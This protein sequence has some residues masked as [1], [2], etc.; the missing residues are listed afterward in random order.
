MNARYT[1]HPL[2]PSLWAATAIPAPSAPPLAQDLEADVVVVGGGFAGLST[3][4]HLAEKGAT[5]CVLEAEQP[6]WGASG[7]NG[8]QVIPGL[9]YDPR[10][11]EERFGQKAESMIHMA[12]TAA[13]TVFD[14]IQKYGIDC[15]PVRNGWIQTAH[16]PAVLDVVEK[17]A[18]DWE[19]R[20]VKVEILD[21][22]AVRKR[23][24]SKQFIGGWVDYRAG[25]V[26]PLSYARGLCHAAQGLG[27]R[28]H[29]QSRVTRL[30]RTG[31]SW[32]AW[33][34]QHRVAAKDVVICT[35]GYT[36][37]LWPR[38]QKTVLPANSFLVATRPLT[39]S[40]GAGILD[41]REVTSDS[42]RLLVYFRRDDEGRLVVGGR[43]PFHEPQS[44]NEW[45]HIERAVTHLFPQ[46]KGIEFQYRWAGRVAVTR[47]FMPHVHEPE[48]GIHMV[49]GFNGRGV[50]MAST[51]GKH[52]AERIHKADASAFPY[53][54][55]GIAA[56]PMH[57]LRGLYMAA[58]VAW[59]RFLDA[60]S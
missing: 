15:R 52:L 14:L 37:G 57:S 12:A 28:V 46:L 27:V 2:P 26:Q 20:G 48:P 5:V 60:L 40:E 53:P 16:S 4:L 43:G 38:L 39:A 31:D 3:A 47:D 51:M 19:S 25:S 30:E 44:F 50:A 11:L 17:R 13:D 1:Q 10:E 18:R 34:G 24:G 7:R 9:K 22:V 45:A 21:Q 36:D 54:I 56:I 58:G 32:H 42:K 41:G 29:G 55:T 8:G 59:Y 6:G 35:N 49:L 23:T 33:A